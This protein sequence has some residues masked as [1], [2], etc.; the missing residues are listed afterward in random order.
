MKKSVVDL[1]DIYHNNF[2][3]FSL[4]FLVK[5]YWVLLIFIIFK[6]NLLVLIQNVPP[7]HTIPYPCRKLFHIVF[8]L[9][10]IEPC[11]WLLLKSCLHFIFLLV[12]LDCNL[13]LEN[14]K[15]W[16]KK[17]YMT[18]KG[19]Q[20]VYDSITERFFRAPSPKIIYSEPSFLIVQ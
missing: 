10:K 8:A 6:F 20:V 14:Q 18:L 17:S 13:L 7:S 19:I 2:I 9:W 11:H 1:S 4:F 12:P 16:M 3:Y 15:K 5:A